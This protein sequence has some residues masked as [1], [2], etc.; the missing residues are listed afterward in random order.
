MPKLADVIRIENRRVLIDGVE[1][2]FYTASK[3]IDVTFD[4]HGLHTVTLIIPTMHVEV[5]HDVDYDKKS[6]EASS[7]GESA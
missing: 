4:P 7:H 5:D 3:T 2:P 6:K 1:L